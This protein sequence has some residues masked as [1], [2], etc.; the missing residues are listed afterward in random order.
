MLKRS[1]LFVFMYRNCYVPAC[2]DS[3]VSRRGENLHAAMHHCVGVLDRVAI[4][5]LLHR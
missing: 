1:F 4:S 2:T 5:G 3:K